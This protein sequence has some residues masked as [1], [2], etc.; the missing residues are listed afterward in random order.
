MPTDDGAVRYVSA[1]LGDRRSLLYAS[2]FTHIQ[3]NAACC[4]LGLTY[5]AY[6]GRQW[7]GARDGTRKRSDFPYTGPPDHAHSWCANDFWE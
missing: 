4:V 2:G 1:V 5:E 7:G 3:L 6:G